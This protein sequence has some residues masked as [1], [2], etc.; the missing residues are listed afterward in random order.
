MFED[1]M[2][3]ILY[4]DDSMT[5]RDVLE[6]AGCTNITADDGEVDVASL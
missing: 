6:T 2:R 4:D 5:A 3:I 1:A